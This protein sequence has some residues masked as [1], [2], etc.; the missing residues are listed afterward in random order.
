MFAKTFR[1]DPCMED[2]LRRL[3]ESGIRT[4]ACCCGHSR[5]HKTIVV[6]TGGEIIELFSGVKIPRKKRFYVKDKDGFYYI[7]EVERQVSGAGGR[8]NE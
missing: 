6:P 5:Y 4:L 7:P 1:I 3:R 2:E 8:V